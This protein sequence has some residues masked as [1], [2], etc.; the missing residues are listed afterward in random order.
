MVEQ[1]QLELGDA[2]A[3]EALGAR[4]VDALGGRGLVFLA[5]E[6][7]TGK[8]TLVRGALRHM[9]HQGSVKS[10]TFT[11]V[12]PYE[13]NSQMVFH[14]DLYRLGDAGELEFMGFRDYIAGDT[15]CFVEWPE[16]GAGGLPPPDI[17]VRLEYRGSGRGA[18]VGA[19]TA[20]GAEVLAGIAGG[21]H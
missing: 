21:E 13:I 6:L 18:V 20:R 15:L 7:G 19:A 8:T 5:G 14:F 9:G 17:E 1:Q 2:E 12:E 16:R 11:L 4:I 10:P 3:M